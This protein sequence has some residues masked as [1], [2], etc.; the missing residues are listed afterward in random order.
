MIIDP[1]LSN[2]LFPLSL[3][4][5]PKTD[6]VFCTH[7]HVDHG[8]DSAIEIANRDNAVLITGYDMGK[9][10]SKM[11]VKNVE[12][13]NPGGFFDVGEIKVKLTHAYHSSDIGVPVGFMIQADG[14]L[15]YHM[16]DT[17]YFTETKDY[18]EMYNI[19]IL[20][21]PVG[22][23]YTMDPYEAKYAIC[24]LNPKMVIPMHYNTFAKIEQ[25]LSDLVKSMELSNINLTIMQPG[26]SIEA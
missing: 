12:S 1:W 10:A 24:N 14:Q 4:D 13:C 6:F 9:E 18:G 8:F 22:G 7:D 26:E 11:G 20:M 16:G 17:G 25:D 21:I 5:I 23:R 3:R 2:P 19:D 15:I